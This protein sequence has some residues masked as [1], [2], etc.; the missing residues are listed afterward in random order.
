MNWFKLVPIIIAWVP[1]VVR[2]V[3]TIEAL[4]GSG[5]TGAEKREAVLLYL[6]ETSTKL[7]LPW[8]D[9]AIEVVDSIIETVVRFL[10]LFRVFS[11]GEQ[12]ALPSQ[13]TPEVNVAQVIH[14]SDAALEAFLNRTSS[15]Q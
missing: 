12:P 1:H 9:Q 3:V 4:F 6:G 7:G 8:G 5:K 13:G 2:G 15:G 14:Q 10:N 11:K